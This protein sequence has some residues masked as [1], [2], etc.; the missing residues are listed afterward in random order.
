MLKSRPPWAG[1]PAQSR[2]AGATDTKDATGAHPAV[3]SSRPHC[4]GWRCLDVCVLLQFFDLFNKLIFPWFHQPRHP[5]GTSTVMTGGH[6]R[7]RAALLTAE[8]MER[9]IPSCGCFCAVTGEGSGSLLSTQLHF[10]WIK[11]SHSNP[12]TKFQSCPEIALW[13]IYKS[14]SQVKRTKN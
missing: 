8:I 6:R 12:I 5:C 3:S 7:V 1:F 4:S 9:F 13:V 14:C 10:N 11:L 2:T